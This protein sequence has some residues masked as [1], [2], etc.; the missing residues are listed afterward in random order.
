MEA[1]CSGRC[2]CNAVFCRSPAA[3]RSVSRSLLSHKPHVAQRDAVQQQH[4]ISVVTAS[5]SKRKHKQISVAALGSGEVVEVEELRG[6]RI[7]GDVKQR[8]QVQYLVK[9][10]DG[11]PDTW[12][13]YTA[14]GAT[15]C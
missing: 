1:S 6:V 2:A 9:W 14:I 3:R 7:V 10:K 11:T 4:C 12:Q 5:R 15:L 8:P 13:V